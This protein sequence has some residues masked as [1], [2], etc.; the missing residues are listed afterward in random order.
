MARLYDEWVERCGV[1][2]WSEVNSSGGPQCH[3]PQC[4]C[5]L[6]GDARADV[7]ERG[8]GGEL[9][10]RLNPVIDIGA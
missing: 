4:P 3:G 6:T 9:D 5:R 10:R 8:A 2:P 1:L 7:I